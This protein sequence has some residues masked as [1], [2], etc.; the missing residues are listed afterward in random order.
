VQA[1]TRIAEAERLK[2]NVQREQTV[3]DR[4]LMLIQN[5]RISR[6]IDQET[7]AILEPA[8]PAKR[9]YTQ[10]IGSLALA[11]IGGLGLGLGMIVLI[12]FRDDRFTSISEVSEKL[13]ANVVGQVPEVRT[14]RLMPPCLCWKLEINAMPTPNLIATC[15]PQSSSWP[16]KASVPKSCSSP[17]HCLTKENPL[18]PP[19]WPERWPWA[20]HE[21]F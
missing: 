16:R 9:S 2:I 14:L 7:L 12:A 11:G 17:A 1:N 5:M 8:I 6:N 4:L 19:I 13:G 18:L 21:L 3:Y 15:A 10:E 20:A